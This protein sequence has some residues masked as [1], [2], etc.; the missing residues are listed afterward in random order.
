[1]ETIRTN[2]KDKLRVIWAIAYKDILDGLKNKTLLSTLVSVFL[3]F[4]LYM[5]GPPLWY[6]NRPPRLVVY[7]AGVSNVVEK[8]GDST[9]FDLRLVSS[10]QELEEHLGYE[11]TEVLGLVLPADFEQDI[12]NGKQIT[13]EGYVD[14]WVSDT[15]LSEKTAFFEAQLSDLSGVPVTINS[16]SETVFTQPDGGFPFRLSIITIIALIFVGM[17]LTAQLTIEE[18]ESKTIDALLVS[19]AGAS[20]IV[21]GK[22]LAGLF[23]CFVVV[24]VMLA[25]NIP[26]VTHWEIL[27][28]AII[29]GAL[30]S[31][32]LGLLL[33][34]ILNI[35]QQVSLWF[36]ILIQPLVIPIFLSMMTDLLPENLFKVIQWIP[37]VALAKALQRGFS[38]EA[39]AETYG[40]ALAYVAF[41]TLV[42]FGLVAWVLRR[43]DR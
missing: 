23:Y 3:I 12:T 36:I 22:A 10:Q 2:S 15:V 4:T 19:P 16:H 40:P 41:S 27:I 13:L 6:G 5:V 20:Q 21:I 9:A 25:F 34:S 8:M 18:K 26:L 39:P 24:I 35:K 14:H 37:T 28:P 38:G 1:M 31:V 33:G 7:D 42:L 30:F 11:D 29:L 32:A 17:N 43:S